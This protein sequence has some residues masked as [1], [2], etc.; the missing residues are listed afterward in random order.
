MVYSKLLGES[1]IGMLY[2]IGAIFLSALARKNI[3]TDLGVHMI[4]YACF[5]HLL[6]L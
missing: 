6:Y 1:A 2:Q 3:V 5:R 4:L